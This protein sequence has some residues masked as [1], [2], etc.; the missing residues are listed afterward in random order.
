[1]HTPGPQGC[2]C[3]EGLACPHPGKHPRTR[4]GRKDASTSP[5]TITEWWIRWPDANI[6]LKTDE[7][8]VLDIDHRHQG[9]HS[10]DLLQQQYGQLPEGPRVISG[11]GSDHYYFALPAD[12]ISVPSSDGLIAP[13]VDIK[14]F[15]GNINAPPSLHASGNYYLWDAL[16][17]PDAFPLEPPPEWLVELARKARPTSTQSYQAGAV[18]PEGSRYN[19]FISLVGRLRYSGFAEDQIYEALVIANQNCAEPE[20]E[21]TL[22]EYARWGGKKE[23]APPEVI[24]PAAL[25][26]TQ[27]I[28]TPVFAQNG[29]ISGADGNRNQQV[30]INAGF[31][32]QFDFSAGIEAD[33][34]LKTMMVPPRFLVEKLIPDGLTILA[35]PAKS[36]KSYFSLSLALATI[37]LGDWC[38]AF[39]VESNGDV[40]FFGLESPPM[41][42]RNRMYQ[43]HPEF[44]PGMRQHKLVFFSGMTALPTFKNGLQS[45][46][47]QIIERYKPRLIVIDP[48]SYLY[49]L[50]KQD[51]LAS[52]TL[53][54]LWP[55][56]EMASK[57]GVAIFAPEHMRKRSKDDVSI[58]EQLAGS[59]IKAAIVHGLLS[60]ERQGDDIIIKTTM[61]DAPS[62]ELGLTLTFDEVQHHVVWG[63]KGASAISPDSRQSIL[64]QKVL[65]ELKNRGYPMK[66]TEMVDALGEMN[67]TQK[68]DQVRQILHRAERDGDVA[69]SK[70]GEYYWIGQ[71]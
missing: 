39:P 50:G 40:V 51:D 28:E 4:H 23:T 32:F 61:R 10:L 21:K 34:L 22:R 58:V 2:S 42:L 66:V 38:D 15:Q 25:D 29:Q 49:R 16:F 30:D 62:Q 63:Y 18:I 13:G 67:T 64:K 57:A 70:R 68:K 20:E 8:F 37:G 36:Y 35:A 26:V 12:G 14:G 48:L 27:V 33:D 19:Y 11:S 55:L 9:H 44:V 3:H 47:E 24:N 60:I 43:L 45:V 69:V 54:L 56:A 46:I 71:K 52:A 59:H 1:M 53:D 65:E 31:G 41:Q 6:A 5:Q 7:L 17:S